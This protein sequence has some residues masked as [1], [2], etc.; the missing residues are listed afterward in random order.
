MTDFGEAIYDALFAFD[1]PHLVAASA[2]TGK[3]Y[4]IQ[5]IYAR[6]VA[7][8]GLQ[9]HEIQVMTFTEAATKELRERLRK[10]LALFRAFLGGEA[11]DEREAGRL[12]GLRAAMRGRGV[13]EAVA[14][15]RLE[16]ALMDFDRA[17]ISTI[18]GFCRRALL[19]YAFETGAPF[20]VELT[21]TD[22]A[23]LER[24]ARDWWRTE[25]RNAPEDVRDALNLDQMTAYVKKLA[26]HPNAEIAG[27]DTPE[28]HILSEAKRI[29]DRYH[30]ERA[31]RTT[32]TFSELLLSL[33][34]ALRG[35]STGALAANLRR[36][37]KA[38]VVD[39]FQDTDPVQYEVFRRV[40]M[41]VPEG[42]PRPALFFVGD[43]K[44]AIYSFRGG[45]IYTYRAAATRDDVA[46][47]TF[48]LGKN[49]RSTPRLI[50]AVNLLFRDFKEDGKAAQYTF[51]DPA[52]DYAE[53]LDADKD[54]EALKVNGADDPH[55]FRVI[56]VKDHGKDGAGAGLSVKEGIV[57]AVVE[58]ALD[59]LSEQRGAVTPKDIA[60]LVSS[61]GKG[62]EIKAA[63]AKRGV[64][65]VLQHA[66]N[67]FGQKLAIEFLVV[68]RA[69]A[70]VEQSRTRAALMTSFFDF[71]PDELE[72]GPEGEAL[73]DA[74]VMFKALNGIWLKHG[75]DAAMAELEKDAH[76]DF[77][78]RFAAMPDGERRLADAMQLIDLSIRAA[79]ERGPSPEALVAW[80]AERIGKSGGEDGIGPEDRN[81]EY[82]RELESEHDAVKIMTMHVSKGL[83]FPVVIVSIP[84]KEA[85]QKTDKG[86]YGYHVD[87]ETL[88]YRTDKS[89]EY[90]REFTDERTRLL[91][92]ALTR[93]TKRTVIVTPESPPQT[94]PV[95]ALLRNAGRNWERRRKDGAQL[96]IL[97]VDDYIPGDIPDYEPSP[98][99]PGDPKPAPERVAFDHGPSKGS[100][101]SLSPVGRGDDEG[102]GFDDSDDAPQRE[103]GNPEHP[104]F[105]IRGG[106][107]VGI[108]WHA[109]LEK[110][111]FA[112]DDEAIAAAVREALAVHGLADQDAET[113]AAMV[114]ATLERRLAAPDGS[115]FSLRDVRAPDRFSE[116]E[117]EF[118]SS[119]AVGTTAAVRAIVERHWA[120]DPSK[121]RFL[122]AME[123]WDRPIP[124]G[125][126]KGYIDLLF[127]HDGCYYVVDWKSN[128]INGARSGF[129]KEGIVAEMAEHGYFFQYL[130]YATVLHRFL[131]DAL[132]KGYSW[133]RHFGGIGYYFLRGVAAG[134]GD[135]VF[136]DRPSR[137]MLDE[138][139]VVLGMEG[140]A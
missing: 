34:D 29:A 107:A 50:D 60:I 64:P 27:S 137:E 118:S 71:T 84:E 36:E 126:L 5:N 83:E 75:F 23:L 77:R 35:D 119:D 26:D 79:R 82:A 114:K 9:V 37:F 14:R 6:L 57:S 42:T 132:G 41:D 78:R 51:G 131:K 25:R 52:I 139:S 81:E 19:R 110:L 58:S 74:S 87:G 39:E 90:I 63:L 88:A 85:S 8:E 68:L 102:R 53:D 20:D 128:S 7:E 123:G 11:V 80:V 49:H 117:F 44:Q 38:A 72:R 116:W 122:R 120:K 134:C 113:V 28:F 69:M 129:S 73:A 66:G 105:A 18:H 31:S 91:Y 104:V 47:H 55:P 94:W 67:V 76:C 43:P 3:T 21:E 138:L 45:D 70:T 32:R 106:N 62:R 100:Y 30:A 4:S 13:D 95:N 109:I 65:A 140:K 98:T 108:C 46:A 130:L 86:P 96:P 24:M 115:S 133:E 17:A 2:G 22:S 15:M 92:V 40:F 101:S 136:C 59:V 135:A 124:K 54:K 121:A 93:A 1:G 12:E 103:A 111:D 56:R 112:A 89:E 125:F 99:P 33:R 48:R 127:R 16:I 10:V 97:T 61:H